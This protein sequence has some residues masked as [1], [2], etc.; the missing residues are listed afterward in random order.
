ME[1]K[2]LLPAPN[3]AKDG[4]KWV[5]FWADSHHKVRMIR[6]Y[7]CSAELDSVGQP[8]GWADQILSRYCEHLEACGL[9][10]R[11]VQYQATNDQ[12][13]TGEELINRDTSEF[14]RWC[15]RNA[16]AWRVLTEA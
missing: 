12:G 14:E 9:C 6:M 5:A 4:T 1:S 16:D 3:E 8:L 11:Q 2:A 15:V 7:F 10:Q 13:N